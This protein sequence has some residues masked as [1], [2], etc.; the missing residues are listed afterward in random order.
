MDYKVP[1]IFNHHTILCD[2]STVYE[3]SLTTEETILAGLVELLEKQG[4]GN[5]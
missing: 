4:N 3:R 5:H 2:E 1:E